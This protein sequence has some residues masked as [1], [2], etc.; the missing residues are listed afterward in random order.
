METLAAVDFLR[1]HLP[2]IQGA[3][4]IVD[5]MALQPKSEHPHGITDVDFETIFTRQTDCVC[6]PWLSLVDSPLTY[7]R[8][9]HS[10]LHVRGYKEEGT[11]FHH[12]I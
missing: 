8:P 11:N 2:D 3:V 4:N 7:R 1:Q 10:N 5:L 6:L 12:P 9:N